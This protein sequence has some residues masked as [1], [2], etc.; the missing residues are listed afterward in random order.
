MTLFLETLIGGLLAGTMYSLVAIGFVL[1]YKASGVFNFAQGAILLFAA[2]LFVTLLEAGM[3]FAL[4]L[5][6]TV[7]ALVVLAVLI[8]RLVL[9]PLTHRSP[10]TL[11]M[12]TLG[13]SYVIEGLAQG[14]MGADV[15]ALDLG[16]DDVPLF[17]GDLLISQFDLAAALTAVVLVGVLALLFNS[18]HTGIALRAVA[19]DTRAALSIGLNL[20]RIWQI[21]WSVAGVTGLVAGLLW[22]ARQGVQFSLSLVVLKALPVLIIGGF[23]SI[24]GAIAGGLIVGAAESLAEAYIGPHIGGGITSWLAYA[25]ALVFVYIRPAGIFGQRAIERV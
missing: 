12:A 17:L 2:L 16:I 9:R 5:A 20:H 23:T 3:S 22:G 1:I 21:V 13:L 10:M 18:T 14:T 25:L 15:H 24:G 11:F 7:A 8:E 6:L 4:T 19:D